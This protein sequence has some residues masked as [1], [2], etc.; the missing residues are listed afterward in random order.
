MCIHH[1]KAGLKS[2]FHNGSSGRL[3]LRRSGAGPHAAG[4]AAAAA[5]Q[6]ALQ[7]DVHLCHSWL[8]LNQAPSLCTHRVLIPELLA[9]GLLL[10]PRGVG[11]RGG[12]LRCRVVGGPGPATQHR[13]Q[14]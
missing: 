9:L 13:Q 11:S 12:L 2:N 4:A 7:G 1:A 8:V 5:Q 10:L 3:V 6:E 14:P